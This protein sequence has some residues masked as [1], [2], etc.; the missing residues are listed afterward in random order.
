M[1]TSGHLVDTHYCDI[2]VHSQDVRYYHIG[3]LWTL[4][5]AIFRTLSI[6]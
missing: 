4:T 3:L 6:T 5:V 2:F 1:A